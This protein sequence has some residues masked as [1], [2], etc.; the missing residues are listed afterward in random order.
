M[1]S[2]LDSGEERRSLATAVQPDGRSA[3]VRRQGGAQPAARL[4]E[5]L[6]GAETAGGDGGRDAC[7]GGRVA[8]VQTR[9]LGRD[10]SRDDADDAF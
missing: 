2:V 5:V 4:G 1:G 7:L 8:V 10:Q 6:G 3:H 9:L